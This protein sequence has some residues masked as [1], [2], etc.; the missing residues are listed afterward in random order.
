MGI[1]NDVYF[2]EISLVLGEKRTASVKA[3]TFCEV[4]LLT[5]EKFTQIKREY[6]EFMEVLK[7]ISS[8]RTTETEQLILKGIIL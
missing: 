2:G 1:P 3:L 5:K 4:L 8:S 7:K 6:P